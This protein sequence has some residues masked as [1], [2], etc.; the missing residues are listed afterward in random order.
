M[1]GPL[2][3]TIS[4]ID[5]LVGLYEE[6]YS[7]DKIVAKNPLGN[8]TP[9]KS[10]VAIK[11]GL[12]SELYKAKN[13]INDARRNRMVDVEKLFT[14]GASPKDIAVTLKLSAKTVT[15]D[16]ALLGYDI[17]QGLKEETKLAIYHFYYNYDGMHA[18]AETASH[19]NL[20]PST[21]RRVV[22]EIIE[23]YELPKKD[24]SDSYRTYSLNKDFFEKIET[25]EQAYYLGI[26]ATDGS[27]NPINNALELEVARK[28]KEIP[29]NF[30]RSIGSNR[31]VRNTIKYLKDTNKFYAACKFAVQ[32][33]KILTDLSQYNIVNNKSLSLK[34]NTSLIPTPFLRHFWR[35]ALD[36]DGWI[37]LSLNGYPNSIGYSGSKEMVKLFA[38]YLEE[39]LSIQPLRIVKNKNI[40]Q[41]SYYTLETRKTIASHLYNDS[42]VFLTRKKQKAL[43]M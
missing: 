4:E 9:S 35:G 8:R 18:S 5:T 40:Y 12:F 31:P 15:T 32:S 20:S 27:I 3:L 28:D 6:G 26:I 43:S 34:V 14:K 7:L 23:I 29:I 2:N 41:I 33:S 10:T 11:L 36:G 30:M 22:K 25:E 21:I 39:E 19:F 16:L 1:T 13:P 37:S 17:N 24:L 38:S 42:N